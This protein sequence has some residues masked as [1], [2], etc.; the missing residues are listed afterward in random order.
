MFN[1]KNKKNNLGFSLLELI[2]AVAIFSLSSYAIATMLIDS[3]ISTKQNSERV[4]AF[5]YAKEGIEAVRSIRDNAWADLVDGDHG[6]VASTSAW[7]LDGSSDL[8]DDKYTRVI[9]IL[10]DEGDS[11][12]KKITTT[13]SWDITPV[14]QASIVL[15]TYLTSWRDS[16]NGLGVVT[17]ALSTPYVWSLNSYDGTVY[18]VDTANGEVVGGPYV[19]NLGRPGL[20]SVDSQGNVIILDLDGNGISKLDSDGNVLW[21][22]YENYL[23]FAGGSEV[24]LGIAIDGTDNIWASTNYGRLL[25][26]SSV[27][28]TNLEDYSAATVGGG[29]AVD[30][31]GDIY[32]ADRDGSIVRKI[33]GATGDSLW[34]SSTPNDCCESMKDV[35]ID[36]DNKVWAVGNGGWLYAFDATTG[37]LIINNEIIG[38]SDNYLTLTLDSNGNVFANDVGS[39][40]IRMFDNDGTYLDSYSILAQNGGLSVDSNNNIW[41]DD[42]DGPAIGKLLSSDYSSEVYNVGGTD[43]SP[44]LQLG[45]ATGFTLQ[46]FVLGRR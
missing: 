24:Y 41:V 26:V 9:N 5:F 10:T 32:M 39:N 44:Y 40:L 13:I 42:N 36:N 21:T 35:A 11:E 3:N 31:I 22:S 23:D 28:G 15:N 17:D 4:E 6:L 34:T 37:D 16:T 25:K 30:S 43:S 1:L 19:T 8:V 12:L 7:T 18:K 2:L 14:R 45:D 33:S 29:I 20:L 38:G 27:D 46:Y